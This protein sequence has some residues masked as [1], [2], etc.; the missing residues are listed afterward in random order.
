MFLFLT[1]FQL[2]KA[3]GRPKLNRNWCSLH[4]KLTEIDLKENGEVFIRNIRDAKYNPNYEYE[5]RPEFLNK[6]YN[7]ND[8]ERLWL[9]V[10]PYAFNQTHAFFSFQFAHDVFLTVS[11]EIRKVTP[12]DFD[13]KATLYK[14]FEAFYF[15]ATEEDTIF[16]RTNVRNNYEETPVYLFPLKVEKEIVKK[17]FLDL[18]EATNMYSKKAFFYRI[19]YRNCLTEILKYLKK[20]DVLKYRNGFMELP[21]IISL[22]YK[23]DL[24]VNLSGKKLSYKEF[25]DKHYITDIASKI[26]RDDNYSI[27]MRKNF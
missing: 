12:E 20:Y 9:V 4:E 21:K 16:V 23:Q 14:N 19:T 24:V 17:V 6:K 3:L 11:Y 26:G 5:N 18:V 13:G 15:F 1:P 8:I 22:L 10:N 27:N 7:V 2:I 25:K